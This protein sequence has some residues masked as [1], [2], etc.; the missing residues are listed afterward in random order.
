MTSV[1][2]YVVALGTGTLFGSFLVA[3]GNSTAAIELLNRQIDRDEIAVKGI[4]VPHRDGNV[5]TIV[6]DY[7]FFCGLVLFMFATAVAL[8][9]HGK[10]APPRIRIIFLLMVTLSI[11]PVW[12]MSRSQGDLYADVSDFISAIFDHT[13]KARMHTTL[14]LSLVFMVAVDLCIEVWKN[15]RTLIPPIPADSAGDREAGKMSFF[16]EFWRRPFLVTVQCAC[17]IQFILSWCFFLAH[18]CAPESHLPMSDFD[19]IVSTSCLGFSSD[20]DPYEGTASAISHLVLAIVSFVTHDSLQWSLRI[21]LFARVCWILTVVM[22]AGKLTALGSLSENQQDCLA[23]DGLRH[24]AGGLAAALAI[25]MVEEDIRLTSKGS[26][27]A[28]AIAS[29]SVD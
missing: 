29:E 17:M 15:P 4:R 24:V 25:A 14:M 7:Q 13:I 11:W 26:S 20:R 12:P 19:P 22:I 3:N 9:A 5:D 8:L 1:I 28:P 2:P 6:F 27:N 21:M 10:R 18:V 16:S 23:F